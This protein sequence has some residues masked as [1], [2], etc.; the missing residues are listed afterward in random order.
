MYP[1]TPFGDVVSGVCAINSFEDANLIKLYSYLL[2]ESEFEGSS[3][4]VPI[5]AFSGG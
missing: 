1:V 4:S 5:G 3:V 2:V